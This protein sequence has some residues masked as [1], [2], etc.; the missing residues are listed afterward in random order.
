MGAIRPTI[1]EAGISVVVFSAGFATKPF[2]DRRAEGEARG[3]C[4][5]AEYRAEAY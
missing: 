3:L 5:R 4:S 1:I 2:L